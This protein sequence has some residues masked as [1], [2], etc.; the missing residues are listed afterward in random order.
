MRFIIFIDALDPNDVKSSC[1]EMYE[2]MVDQYDVGV[3]RVTPNVVS[4]AMTGLKQEDM[5]M[6]RSTPLWEPSDS[7][8]RRWEHDGDRPK[9]VEGGPERSI[10]G[11]PVQGQRRVGIHPYDNILED[12]DNEDVS[13][14][15]Y[16]TPFCSFVDLDNGMS[17]YD[18]MTNQ[19]SPAFMEFASPPTQFMEDDWDIIYDSYISDTVLELETMKQIARQGNVDAVFLGYKHIDHC[20]HWYFPDCKQAL[21]RVLWAYIQDLREMGHEVMWWS[22]HGSQPKNHVFNINKWLHEHGYLS[23]TI[24]QEFADKLEDKGMT[25][26]RFDQQ[27]QLQHPAV[28]VDWDNTV[29]FS[30]D[31]FDSMVDVPEHA[32]D[33][34]I[35]QVKTHLEQHPAIANVWRKAEKLDPDGDRYHYAPELIVERAPNVLVTGNIHPDVPAFV[36]DVPEDWEDYPYD[37]MGKRPGVHSPY[38]CVGGDIPDDVEIEDGK[39]Y[40]LRDVMWDFVD[41]DSITTTEDDQDGVYT[42][43]QQQQV[44]DR[45][46]ELGYI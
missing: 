36:E 2:D 30:T 37:N 28:E 45:L 41:P 23:Y 9:E 35:D 17:V 7:N 27:M 3:P 25:N 12:L 39:P 16:G 8:D 6:M 10:N 46:E 4:Q 21:I 22:D 11:D 42:E 13:V 44:S 24:D 43:D 40:Q 31:A 15:Q 34:M 38:G 29:A 33:D 26:S 1:P 32:D 20:T 18:E 14:F 5:E 19:Q